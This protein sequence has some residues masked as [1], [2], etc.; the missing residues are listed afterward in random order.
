MAYNVLIVDDSQTMRRV[1]R[2]SVE[3]S[4]FDLGE[5]WE[6]GN[7]REALDLLQSHWIDLILT[8][9]NMP[10][11]NGLEMLRELRKDEIHRNT[12]VVL[13][14]TEGNEPRIREAQALG[15]NGY[16]QKPFHPEA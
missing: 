7:G 2:K 9:L 16:V 3:I 10:E 6:A 14:T 15:M 12:P 11:L 13:I 1:I 5:C 8:D 4:G